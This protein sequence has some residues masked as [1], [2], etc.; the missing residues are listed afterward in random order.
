MENTTNKRRDFIKGAALAGAGAVF[1]PTILSA[2]KTRLKMA[3]SWAANT[4]ILQEGADYFAQTLKT[5]SNGDIDIK[6][7]PAGTLV[8]ALGVFDA[9]SAGQIDIYHSATYY[10]SGKNS[11]FNVYAGVPFGMIDTEMNAWMR[12]GGGLELWRKLAAR[13]NLYPLLGG[14]T[15]IQMGGWFRKPINS[16]KDI[17]GLKMRMPGLGAKVL[18]KLGAS[19]PM[20]PGG[21]IFLALERGVIDATEW[22][23]PALDISTGFQKIAKYYYTGWHEPASTAEIVFNKKIW[24]SLSKEQQMLIQVVSDDM[25]TRMTAM[26]QAQNATAL[27]K[28]IEQGVEVKTLPQDVLEAFNKTFKEVIEE[29]IASNKDFKEAWESYNNFFKG[30][31][32]W[33]KVGIEQYLQNRNY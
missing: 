2:K 16:L 14:N 12:F 19:T 32:E 23:S 27:N 1:V 3:T 29:E 11:A 5:L 10:W 28:L 8:P 15:G 24:D 31:K 7:Y 6:I 21:E 13:Y 20:L 9:V 25:N 33:S 26:F 18:T 4:P 17:D 22:V 30:Q